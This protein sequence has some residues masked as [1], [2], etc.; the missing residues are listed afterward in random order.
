MEMALSFWLKIAG[1]VLTALLVALILNWA[2]PAANAHFEAVTN[3][4]VKLTEAFSE[5]GEH[6]EVLQEQMPEYAK[7][8]QEMMRQMS[9]MMK[10]V[11]EK[12]GRATISRSGGSEAYIIIN[13]AGGADFLMGFKKAVITYSMDGSE[14]HAVLPIK[15]DFTPKTRDEYTHSHLFMFSRKAAVDL[16]MKGI[17]KGV[18]VSPAEEEGK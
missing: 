8:Q 17:I 13:S 1:G 6:E 2:V 12:C 15:G 16:D 7:N 9:V 11:L 18:C 14:H 4:V 5:I 10:V 3:N